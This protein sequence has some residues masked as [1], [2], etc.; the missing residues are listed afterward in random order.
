MMSAKDELADELFKRMYD[1]GSYVERGHHESRKDRQE[2][3]D[4]WKLRA[5]MT[6][7]EDIQKREVNDKGVTVIARS[8]FRESNPDLD[9]E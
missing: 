5:I 7:F 1:P 2:P 4:M 3:L 9:G 8:A 6:Y